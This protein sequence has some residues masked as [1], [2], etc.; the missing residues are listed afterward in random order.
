MWYPLRSLR[1]IL[2]SYNFVPFVKLTGSK[3]LH[4]YVPI[5]RT[6]HIDTVRAIARWLAQQLVDAMPDEVTLEIRKENRKG[7]LFIDIIRNSF[8]HTSVAA[9]SV[10]TIEGAPVAAPV[11]WQ[12]LEQKKVTRS[13]MFT[14]ATMQRRI[15]KQGDIWKNI[16]RERRYIRYA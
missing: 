9:Y 8:T 4:I 3:G 5:A 1:E 2:E 12:E 14:I 16:V 10:R 13:Q 7:R 6:E 15:D 11:T